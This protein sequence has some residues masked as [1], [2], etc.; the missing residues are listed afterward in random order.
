MSSKQLFYSFLPTWRDKTLEKRINGKKKKKKQTVPQCGSFVSSLF[1]ASIKTSASRESRAKSLSQ[2]APQVLPSVK[3]AEKRRIDAREYNIFHIDSI[4]R[5]QLNSQISTV[6][7]LER[8]LK[9]ALWILRCGTPK[10][11]VTAKEQTSVLR[12]QIQDL[13]STFT[14]SFY[15]LRTADILEE[16]RKIMLSKNSRS[17]VCF[18]REAADCEAGKRDELVTKYLRVAREYVEIENYRQHTKK[19]MCPACYN[20][21]LRR[22]SDSDTTFVCFKCATEVQILDGTP[23]FKDIDRVDLRNRYTYSRKGH[24]IDAIKKFQGKQNIDSEVIQSIINVLLDAIKFHNL[25]SDTITKQ[26]VFMFLTEK[27]LSEHYDDVN[28]FHRIITGKP[29]P[30]ISA[31]KEK[32][33]QDYDKQESALDK[34]NETRKNSLNVYYKL[35]KLLQRN[36]YNCC[37]D[38]FHILKTKSKEAEHDEKMKKAWGILGWKWVE[39]F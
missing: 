29:C 31:Y 11:Q 16:Y 7:E 19:L 26:H 8:E 25:K 34:V 22:A 30:D 20:T 14:L 17:F 15:I 28:L 36:G 9:N 37:K 33:L 23:S 5:D 2:S 13:E 35:Y 12:R 27:N 6:N 32:L 3:I 18:D 39:T 38:D 4:I 21:D 1:T 10:D 24:F